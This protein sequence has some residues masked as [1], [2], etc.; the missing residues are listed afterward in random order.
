MKHFFIAALLI[1]GPVA[2]YSQCEKKSVLT[3]PKTEHLAADSSVERSDD[4]AITV[5]FD[6]STFNVTGPDDGPLTGKVDSFSCNWPTPYKVG[7]TRLKVTLTNP[8]GD[9]QHVTIIIEGKEG[10][11]IL[12]ASDDEHSEGKIRLIADKFAEK[13]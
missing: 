5:E 7:R 10:K 6:R 9:S 2:G 4:G 1:A 11:V 12:L 3:A 13:L 8:R